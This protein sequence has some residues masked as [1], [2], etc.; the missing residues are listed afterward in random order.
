MERWPEAAREIHILWFGA[1][2][3]RQLRLILKLI[4]LNTPQIGI[5]FQGYVN[6]WNANFF[7]FPSLC[8]LF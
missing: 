5:D 1:I 6:Y 3:V 8:E 7:W 4:S 2:A